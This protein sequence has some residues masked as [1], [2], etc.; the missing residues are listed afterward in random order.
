LLTN[1]LSLKLGI[2]PICR[3]EDIKQGDL[4]MN[5]HAEFTVLEVTDEYVYIKDNGGPAKSIT[6]DAEWV[7]EQ[8]RK[9]Y[10][11]SKRRVF[12]KDTSGEIDELVHVNGVFKDFAPCKNREEFKWESETLKQ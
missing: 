3:Q 9:E 4:F 5:F 7:V 8:L 2:G 11:L 12:Y 10:G 1:W 6:N